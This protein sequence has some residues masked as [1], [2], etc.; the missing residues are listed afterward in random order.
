MI[1]GMLFPKLDNGDL[2]QGGRLPYFGHFYI[3]ISL[4]LFFLLPPGPE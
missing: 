1:K 3:Q 2:G 4:L